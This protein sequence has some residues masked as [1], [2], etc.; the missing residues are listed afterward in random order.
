MRTSL[1]MAT[2]CVVGAG[3]VGAGAT[4]A[5]QTFQG[6]DT[7]FNLTNAA[8]SSNVIGTTGVSGSGLGG[9]TDYQGG[10]S[11]AGES[12]MAATAPTQ[13]MSPM[14]KMMTSTTCTSLVGPSHAS[15]VVIGL[16][17]VDVYSSTTAGATAGCSNTSTT[18]NNGLGLA[19]NTSL[20]YTDNQGNAQTLTFKNWTDVLALLYGG[21]DKSTITGSGAT[22]Q[23]YSDCSSPQRKALA[24]NWANLF[25]AKGSTCASNPSSA[26]TTASYKAG[27]GNITFGGQLRHAFR[28]DD[29]SGTSDAFA[30]IIGLGSLYAANTTT[31]DTAGTVLTSSSGSAISY[32]VSASKNNG[33][34]VTPYCNSMNWDTTAA[35]EPSSTSHCQLHA[36]KQLVGP[37]GVDQLFCSVGGAACA[38][39]STTTT[40]CNSTGV[41]QWDGIHKRPP[42][43]TWG[44]ASFVAPAG[45]NIGYDVQPT[46]YQ[47]ND[48]IR[49][50]CIGF[51]T[52]TAKPAEEVCNI[53]NPLGPGAGSGGQLGL[54][55]ALPEVDWITQSGTTNCNGALC[56]AVAIY[57]T[58]KCSSF[59]TGGEMQVFRCATQNIKNN[60]CPDG[61]AINGG[62]Q[63]P[64]NAAGTSFCE[65]YGGFWP[66][67]TDLTAN[68]GRIFN[69]VAYDGT[70]AGG[71]IAYPIPGSTASLNFTGA[72][73]RIH[74]TEPI[75]DTSAS[76]TPPALP[77]GGQAQGP[78]QATSMD[79]QMGCLTQA[80]PCS[81]GYAG[82]GAKGWNV[83]QGRALAVAGTDALEVA[84]VY[85]TTS[86]VQN[87]S[88][89]LWR[90]LYYNTS[91]G[92][93]GINGTTLFTD[94]AGVSDNGEAELAL[95]QFE[96]NTASVTAL[97]STYGFFS[98]SNSPNGGGAQP[99]CEDFN[100]NILCSA[101]TFPTN[102]NACLNNATAGSM[103]ANPALNPAVV[104]AAGSS[105]I[106]SVGTT[107]GNGTLEPFED[108]DFNA[109]TN[110]A[111]CSK[112]CRTLL[113]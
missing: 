99:F 90:K 8:I 74:M 6:S 97:L 96:S 43:N 15:G 78:C 44:D 113:P 11:G 33:F 84:Q 71:P 10:G 102:T 67:G 79:D 47:D 106:P 32:S 82:D 28:R 105:S 86:G 39:G 63:M 38:S 68:D 104:N 2:L 19:F 58:A 18:G 16:D 73:T 45:N 20:A 69:L 29:A 46:A 22:Q 31:G 109:A 103:A 41:C 25:E 7:L 34:G 94:K 4:F 95:G 40:V 17:A 42:P 83:H 88:Y 60:V 108:C 81:I 107:C 66:S 49:R 92:F 24:A 3:A 101:T 55:L 62:C 93:D 100:E 56:P 111:T 110:A 64:N 61:A 70:S 57:P 85:A 14:S 51:S 54:V 1:F 13:W 50:Q 52:Q 48:P 59:V 35:N 89:Q 37:G 77:G 98:L 72:F 75:W 112:T 23:G 76:A 5:T 9:T 26:C 27:S 30:G 21:L 12:A 87:G 65:N 53:D 80:D 36:N 91:N